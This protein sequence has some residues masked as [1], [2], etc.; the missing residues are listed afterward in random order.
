MRLRAALRRA[1]SL[2]RHLGGYVTGNVVGVA[3]AEPA[4]SINLRKANSAPESNRRPQNTN[5]SV[6]DHH[7]LVFPV[8][9]GKGLLIQLVMI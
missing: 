7:N 6:V 2:E 1:I 5:R 3:G 9:Q 4:L 8:A